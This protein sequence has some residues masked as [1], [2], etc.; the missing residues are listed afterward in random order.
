[1]REINILTMGVIKMKF[2]S[3]TATDADG[4]VRPAQAKRFF[5]ISF[6]VNPCFPAGRLEDHCLLVQGK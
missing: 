2:D 4:S 1:M 3:H 5:D 6:Y